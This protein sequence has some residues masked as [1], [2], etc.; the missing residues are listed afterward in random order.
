M[1]GIINNGESN[2]SM[3]QLTSKSERPILD[4]RELLMR[5]EDALKKSKLHA[6][7]S[8]NSVEE[9]S[10]SSARELQSSV[11]FATAPDPSPFATA[12]GTLSTTSASCD[13][14]D[15]TDI[16][17]NRHLVEYRRCW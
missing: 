7:D 9:Y 5:Y 11:L 15:T 6:N 2:V 12:L 3:E 13:E 1:S 16:T 4:S 10:K 17:L 14:K 8:R